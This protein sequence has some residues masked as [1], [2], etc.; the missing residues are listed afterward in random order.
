MHQRLYDLD[1]QLRDTDETGIDLS[2][3]SCLLGWSASLEE[4]QFINRPAAL[5][6]KYPSCLSVWPKFRCSMANRRP[7]NRVRDC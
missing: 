6:K 7:M 1:L 5:M 3:H 2:V 4:S